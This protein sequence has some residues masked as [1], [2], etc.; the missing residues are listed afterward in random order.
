M[1]KPLIVIPND[2]L[3]DNHQAEL[4]DSLVHLNHLKASTVS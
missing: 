1:R 4:A 2:T 3:M